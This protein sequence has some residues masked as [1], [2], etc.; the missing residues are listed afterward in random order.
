MPEPNTP[1]TIA[2]TPKQENIVACL[3]HPRFT[4][5]Y[6]NEW[7]N[8]NDNVMIN[9]PAALMAVEA[10]GFYEAVKAFERMMDA[11]GGP[12]PA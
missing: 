3:A 4:S 7:I 1:N 11:K 8:R 12:A 10:Q 9:A 5:D 2:L 6:L